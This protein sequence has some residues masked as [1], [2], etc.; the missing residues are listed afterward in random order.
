MVVVMDAVVSTTLPTTGLRDTPAT[1]SSHSV[2]PLTHTDY[3]SC[4]PP[5][6]C[7]PGQSGHQ[8]YCHQEVPG[9]SGVTW[10]R[11]AVKW[12]VHYSLFAYEWGKV[13]VIHNLSVSG[14]T[15][16]HGNLLK[17][18]ATADISKAQN[19]T[20]FSTNCFVN[21]LYIGSWIVGSVQY[22]CLSPQL[23]P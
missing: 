13:N 10:L 16:P 7:M 3:N 14:A 15:S 11:V 2:A 6:C 21:C 23:H 4:L 8:D 22:L 1:L 12:S 19:E 5:S 17:V 9:W 18:V 20:K